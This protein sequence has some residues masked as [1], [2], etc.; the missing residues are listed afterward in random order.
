[1]KLMK[2]FYLSLEIK[3]VLIKTLVALN[4]EIEILKR[5]HTIAIEEDTDYIPNIKDAKPIISP[6]KF[7]FE[8]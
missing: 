3:H 8:K 4:T 7:K 2:N 1:M 5:E 6:D